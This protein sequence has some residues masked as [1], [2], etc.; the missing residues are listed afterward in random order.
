MTMLT[1]IRQ[2]FATRA[3]ATRRPQ[4]RR[5]V[6]KAPARPGLEA[7]EERWVPSVTYHGG[8]VLGNVE[9]QALYYGSN[10]S[11]NPT[12]FSQTGYFEGFLQSTVN[13]SYM[14]MLGNAGYG[15]GRGSWS[16]GKIYLANPGSTIS[17]GDIRGAIQNAIKSGNPLAAPDANRLYVVFVEPNV[18]VIGNFASSR[19]AGLANSVQDFAGYHTAFAGTDAQGHPAT[20]HYAIVTTPG[21]SVGNGSANPNLGT[22]NAM[23]LA[24]SH[25]LAEAVTDP[26]IGY[27][28]LGWNDDTNGEIGDIVAGQAV[29]VNGY[30]VQRE[31]DPNDQGMTPA[32]A[33]SD[34][35]VNFVLQTNGDL[36]EIVNGSPVY[37]ASGIAALSPQGIDNNGHALVD[38]VT[39]G[40]DA[41]EY[42]DQTGWNYL[43]SGV[44]SAVAGQGVSYVLYTSGDIYE[45]KEAT[46]FSG[47]SWAYVYSSASQI[48]AGTDKLGVNCVDIVFSWGDAYEHS[49]DSGW[50]YIASNV[51]SISA[52]R[53]GISDYLTTDG[54]AHWHRESDGADVAVFSNV[55]QVAAGTDANGNYLIDVLTTDGTVSEYRYG[56]SWTT[57]DNGV[58]NLSKGTLDAVDMVF[59]WGDAYQH[60]QAGWN[61]L[62]GSAAAA[63]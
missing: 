3:S 14:D 12:L 60:S 11:T 35:V 37:L 55:S 44:A 46:G 34:R 24:A 17:D 13:S 10:W 41:W 50:H 62:Y 27:R 23:T 53:Q 7:L 28:T 52:G 9:A 40:G 61:Y 57:L 4:A 1:L 25:E 31:S 33:A 38:V 51:Q 18:E 58:T 36:Y 48:D 21:G 22:L 63:A 43:T 15:V 2:L 16:G 42:H 49:D 45:Y 26:N 19:H 56:G 59:S 47:S 32:Q 54:V 5:A 30:A 20:I 39:T 8:A 29:Y 6:S